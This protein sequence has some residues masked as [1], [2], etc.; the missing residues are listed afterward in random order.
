MSRLPTGTVTFLFTDI[1]GSTRLVQ[2]LG[3]TVSKQIFADHR[4]LL[5]ETVESAG[6]NVYQD[7]GESFVFARAKDAVLAAVAAQRVL[8]A[9]AWADSCHPLVRMGLHTGEPV[10]D[11][12]EYV[13]LDVHR[14]ARICG[15]GHGGQI[16][17]SL[18]TRELIADEVPDG[19]TFRD[20][21]EHRL[22]DLAR[23]HRLFQIVTGDL[24]SDFPPLTSRDLF[25]NNLPRQLTSF[26]GREEQIAEVKRLL[27]TTP[28]L[29]LTGVG[30]VGKTRLALEVAAD[31]LDRFKDG[32]WLVELA[33]LS[34]H[35]LV[36]QSVSTVLGVR[37]QP[38]RPIL[39]TISEFLQPKEHLLVLDNA[40]HLIAACAQRIPS[41]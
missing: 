24:P 3:D 20:L 9:H 37:E 38:G 11:A 2:N 14:A 39:E 1:E 10:G 19:I 35:S 22:K 12:G 5:V 16:L 36:P 21:G 15:A 6:G 29:T 27:S 23:P 30:G 28:L 31:V 26:I 4:R 17:L 41:E 25:P 13:G 32:I 7:Q 33:P 8:Q 40:E 18:T 34:D